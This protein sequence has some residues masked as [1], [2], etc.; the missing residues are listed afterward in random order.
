M[1]LFQN[2][3]TGCGLTW[4]QPMLSVKSRSLDFLYTHKDVS[5]LVQQGFITSNKW[6]MIDKTF[7]L[8]KDQS[9]NPILVWVWLDF[10]LD[11]RGKK[12]QIRSYSV[13]S[14]HAIIKCY[15]LLQDVKVIQ[16]YCIN[17]MLFFL[18]GNSFV[19]IISYLF[20][21]CMRKYYTEIMV[22]L[23]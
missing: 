19:R 18:T 6:I 22:L 17:F 11:I 4:K 3:T 20:T 23:F 1:Q 10:G 2:D 16:G 14:S 13:T 8:C 7:V 5:L 9:I 12:E 21:F 15:L